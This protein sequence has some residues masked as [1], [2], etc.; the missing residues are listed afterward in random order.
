MHLFHCLHRRRDERLVATGE[1]LYLHVSR[2]AGKASPMDGAVRARLE[3]IRAA[4]AG[5]AQPARSDR[6]LSLSRS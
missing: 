2:E 4:H 1:Q 6:R 5:I 3:K